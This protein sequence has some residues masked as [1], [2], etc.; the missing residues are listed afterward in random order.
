MCNI[1]DWVFDILDI[2]F[3]VIS[4]LTLL[5]FSCYIGESPFLIQVIL[6]F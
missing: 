6:N 3:F 4:K 5:Y 1:L 2:L